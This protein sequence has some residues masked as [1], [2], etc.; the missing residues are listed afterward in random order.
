MTAISVTSKST[1]LI[2]VSGKVHF[3]TIFDLPFA[4]CC[5]ATM[6]RLAPVT[7]G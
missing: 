7:S 4:A 5:M 6:T 3:F 1:G 2:D